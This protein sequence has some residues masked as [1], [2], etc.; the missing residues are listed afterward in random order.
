MPDDDAG[1]RPD[2]GPASTL[3]PYRLTRIDRADLTRSVRSR[4]EALA[5]GEAPHDQHERYRL[6]QWLDKLAE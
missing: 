6:R 5:G 2:V 1:G 3:R 4:L